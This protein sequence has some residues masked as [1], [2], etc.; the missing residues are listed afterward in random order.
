MTQT[1]NSI[2][3]IEDD[4]DI[5]ELIADNLR[6]IYNVRIAVNGETALSLIAADEPQLALID[7]NLPGQSGITVCETIRTF[8]A[9]PVIMLSAMGEEDQ[10][11]LAYNAGANEYLVKPPELEV[12]RH[13]IERLIDPTLVPAAELAIGGFR[14][15]KSSRITTFNGTKLDLTDQDFD[16]LFLLAQNA[17]KVLTHQKLS[18]EL[19]GVDYDPFDGALKNSIKRLRRKLPDDLIVSVRNVGY[20]LVVEPN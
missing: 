15:S 13:K 1:K 2:L 18:K 4:A 12:L 3:I 11:M 20:Q 7:V 10:K 6:E 5:A 16:L 9:L 19:R 17:G 14:I 8:S